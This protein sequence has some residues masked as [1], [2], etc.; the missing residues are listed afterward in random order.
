MKGFVFLNKI[1]PLFVGMGPISDNNGLA[2]VG[3]DELMETITD[4]YHLGTMHIA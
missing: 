1:L 2:A 4:E 3:G